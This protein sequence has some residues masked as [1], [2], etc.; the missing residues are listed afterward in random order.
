[1]RDQISRAVRNLPPDCNPPILIKQ[2]ADSNPILGLALRSDSRDQ[3]ELSAYADV[4][5][6]RL[7]TVPGVAAVDQPAEKRYS[8]RLWIDPAKLAAYGLTP[9]DVRTALNREN[10]ELPSGRIEGDAVEL[11]IKAMS[12]LNTPAE[13]NALV[14]KRSEDRIVRF[15]DVGFAELGPQN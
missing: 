14:L 2:N 5:K 12:R 1:V 7:Q 11:P 3:L 9:L 10:I 8:M 13:F 4:L 15:R 6:E